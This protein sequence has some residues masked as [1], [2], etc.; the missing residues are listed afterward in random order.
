MGE[1]YIERVI[2]VLIAGG[3]PADR[4]CPGGGMPKLTKIGAA[5]SL[6]EMDMA[7]KTMTVQVLI[8]CPAVLGAAACEDTAMEAA[9]LMGTIGGRAR[10]L[11]CSFDGQTGLFQVAVRTQFFAGTLPAENVDLAI[12]DLPVPYVVSF[13][14]SREVSREEPELYDTPWVFTME[15]WIPGDATELRSFAMP[16][17]MVLNGK[18]TYSECVFTSQK[19]ILLP[20]GIRQ[21]REGTATQRIMAE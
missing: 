12:E 6:Q 2:A 4:A 21:I 20:D 9:R 11:S 17:E 8:L 18:E 10:V 1:W 14:A 3:I 19:R 5:V 7:E 13:T 15:E 16:F